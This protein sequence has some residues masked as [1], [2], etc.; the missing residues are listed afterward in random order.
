MSQR[1]PDY[2]A[3][4]ALQARN[5]EADRIGPEPVR[6]DR[7]EGD[8]AREIAYNDWAAV[9]EYEDPNE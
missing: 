1:I 2:E 6:R 7:E 8:D 4:R 3:L 5:Q 9:D